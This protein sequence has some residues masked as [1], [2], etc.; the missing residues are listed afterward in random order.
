MFQKK[1]P[2]NNTL[3]FEK[4]IIKGVLS[5]HILAAMSDKE[6]IVEEESSWIANAAISMPIA[7]IAKFMLNC[8]QTTE[9][10][11]K[12]IGVGLQK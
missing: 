8:L 3:I 10:D 11:K 2:N 7:N 9:Y 6:Y 4:L 12:I 1:A 5:F